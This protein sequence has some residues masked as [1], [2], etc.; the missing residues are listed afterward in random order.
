MIA[1]RHLLDRPALVGKRKAIPHY[2]ST[3]QVSVLERLG[4]SYNTAAVG[5]L[6]PDTSVTNCKYRK[7]NIR[8]AYGARFGLGAVIRQNSVNVCFADKAAFDRSSSQ[9]PLRGRNGH[10]H[11]GKRSKS[12]NL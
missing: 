3:E 9:R 11:L 5:F 8:S 7:S 2:L 10:S 6:S 4:V 12:A 1:W